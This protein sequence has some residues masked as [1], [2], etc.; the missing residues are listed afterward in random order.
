MRCLCNLIYSSYIHKAHTVWG[1]L[2]FLTATFSHTKH[3]HL[4]KS[5]QLQSRGEMRLCQKSPFLGCELGSTSPSFVFEIFCP[6]KISQ[7]SF[8]LI[9]LSCLRDVEAD[10]C[11]GKVGKVSSDSLTEIW[12][13]STWL[14]KCSSARCT[15]WDFIHFIK[16]VLFWN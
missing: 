12:T 13:D 14:Q 5:L 10:L 4:E 11:H 9:W 3:G 2:H 7:A 8:D 1:I 16:M 15:R 6:T